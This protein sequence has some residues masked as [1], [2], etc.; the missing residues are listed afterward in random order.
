MPVK[1]DPIAD[2]HVAAYSGSQEEVQKLLDNGVPIDAEDMSGF[3]A[4]FFAARYQ[5]VDITRFLLE[6][7]ADVRHTDKKGRTALEFARWA[8]ATLNPEVV[9][10]LEAAGTVQKPTR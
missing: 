5:H 8:N 1:V 3:T 9:S 7:G 10:L 4:L 6:R 2:L